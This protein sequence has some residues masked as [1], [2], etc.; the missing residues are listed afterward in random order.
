MAL[1]LL[2]CVALGKSVNLPELHFLICRMMTTQIY[3]AELLW[4]LEKRYAKHQE[5]R[6][7][8]TTTIISLVSFLSL[9]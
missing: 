6:A 9:F 1:P 8:A 4:E 7:T 5:Q 2:G 3:L